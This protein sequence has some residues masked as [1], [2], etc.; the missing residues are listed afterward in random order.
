MLSTQRI[1][2]CINPSCNNPINP[3]GDSLC[4]SCQT[5]LVHRYLWATGSFSAKIVPGTKVADRYE[6]ITRQIWLDTQPGLPPDVPEELPKE[7]VPYLRLY[8]ERLHLPQAYGFARS[9]EEDADD[10]LLLENV[11]I[12]ETGHIYPT[13]NDAWEQATAVRQV[14]WLWQILQLWTPL[15]E[16]GVAHSLLVLDNLRVQGWC[17]R[18]LELLETFHETSLQNL[19]QSW[20]PWV[21]SAK[22]P[23]AEKLKNIVQQMC[24]AEI[25]LEAIST[26]LNELLLSSVAELPLSLK[27][28]GASDTGPVM[29]QNEDSYYPTA[30]N[31]L[32]HPILPHLSIVCDGIGGHEGGEVASQLAVQ[33]LRLQIRALLAEVA[34]QTE[35]VPP[36]LLQEQLE[37]SLRVVNNV[38]YARNQEQKR[39]GRERMA[40]TL[41]MAV[42]VPQR[43]QTTAGWRSENAHELY[44]V[45]VGDSR[46]YWITHNYCQLLTVDDDV[47]TREVRFARSLYRKA[48][49]RPDATALT[50]AL[51][52]KDA[53]SLHIKIQRFILEEDGILLLC[54]DGLSDNN[55]VE[56]SWQDYAI[57]VL[58]RQLTVEDAVRDLINLANTKNGHDNT[59]VVLTYCRVSSE[60]LVPFTP[61]QQSLEIVEAEPQEQEDSTSF[62]ESSQALLDLDL[63]LDISEEPF[64]SPK[65]PQTLIKKPN[66]G[67]RLVML[68]RVL[69]LLVGSTSLGLFAWL[70]LNPQGFQQI[71]RQLPQ[72][73]QQICPP[74][75]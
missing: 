29:I 2:Y 43:V 61:T 13:I 7:V 75:N 5:L 4:A 48:L 14:Y 33:S 31:N 68:A 55:W 40:T 58:I 50:Q 21:A 15:S 69:A 52:T 49:L 12:D 67:K 16:L 66:R 35:L 46:A 57:P 20:Q 23:V 25:E 56:Q 53:E 28:A 64:I 19:G 9:F 60:Y 17:V 22:T 62:T 3:V 74:G 65:I 44:L 6:V 71:C 70:Q 30:S 73:V 39:Q 54:S 45:N 8:Q 18:L 72:G 26:Q 27:V 36:K 11:P 10:I 34:E 37:A 24:E 63:D 38:I 51:G 59:S 1:I 47:A 42:Q 41:V 32:D